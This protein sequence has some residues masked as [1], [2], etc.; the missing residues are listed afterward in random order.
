MKHRIRSTVAIPAILLSM[1]LGGT[2]ACGGDAVKASS[3][4]KALDC[5]TAPAAKGKPVTIRIAHGKAAEEPVW[6]MATMP[7]LTPHQ[8]KSYDI[9]MRAYDNSETKLVA[10]QAGEVDAVVAPSPAVIVGTAKGALDLVALFT[11]MQEAGDKAFGTSFVVK[12]DSKIKSL[13][14]LK[15]TNIG[16]L[17]FRST[18]DFLA[19]MA[20]R[21]AGYKTADAKFVTLP[22]PAQVESLNSGVVDVAAVAEPFAT[23]AK[24]SANPPRVLFTARD[25]TGYA[26]DQLV[27]SVDR[28]FAAKNLRAVCDFRDDYAKALDWYRKN[29]DKAKASVAKAGY[30]K[31]PLNVYEQAQDYARPT[32]GNFDPSS[33]EPLMDDMSAVGLLEEK[34]RVDVDQLFVHG[35]TAGN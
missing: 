18:P 28:K 1:A 12:R 23:I 25:V 14:D 34:D 26:Y 29:T 3:N 6:L 10:Y 35:F 30:V 21:K 22:F 27:L 2:A 5:S 9:A 17:D 20:L 4:D 24:N 11:V 16:I 8:G 19:R 32:R 31:L 15:G 33:L 13:A 7:E